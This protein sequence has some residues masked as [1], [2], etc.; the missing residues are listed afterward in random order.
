MLFGRQLKHEIRREALNISAHSLV[1]VFGLYLLQIGQITVDEHLV[2][3]NDE[4][5]ARNRINT[6]DRKFFC[7]H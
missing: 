4:N 6:D 3:T 7:R 2:A 1:E 5:A